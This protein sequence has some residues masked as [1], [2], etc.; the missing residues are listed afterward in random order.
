MASGTDGA[1]AHASY[2]LAT[3]ASAGH[4]SEVAAANSIGHL[5]TVL[6][7]SSQQAA[8]AAAAVLASV[9]EL[10]QSK[11]AILRAGALLPL[12]RQLKVGLTESR[13]SAAL[14]MA[15]L[16]EHGRAEA[17]AEA[18]AAVLAADTVPV[19]IAH[20]ASGKAQTAAAHCLAALCEGCDDAQA[21]VA[22]A[23]GSCSTVVRGL[24]QRFV[25][26]RSGS[27]GSLS[28]KVTAIS[29]SA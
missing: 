3:L 15:H 24:P 6:R 10:P 1:Q 23:G 16:C 29:S 12:V 25:S 8:A 22:A 18:Q 13:I 11:P 14:T 19:L 5:V 27:S 28:G 17:R 4:R 7:Q 21:A 2:A 20:L 9:S 26:S